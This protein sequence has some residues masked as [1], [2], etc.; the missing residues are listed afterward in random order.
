MLVTHNICK[1]QAALHVCRPYSTRVLPSV[2]CY[3]LLRASIDF[4]G[5]HK[6]GR[7]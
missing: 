2:Y 7:V 1:L 6:K 4:L 3:L 5:D